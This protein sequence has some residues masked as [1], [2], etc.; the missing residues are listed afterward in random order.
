MNKIEYQES[1]EKLLAFLEKGFQNPINIINY[2][3][4]R[5]KCNE[6]KCKTKDCKALIKYFTDNNS[7]S[8]WS[9]KM[10]DKFD[11]LRRK[12]Y[13]PRLNYWEEPLNAFFTLPRI[14]QFLEE[15][16]K[17]SSE[18]IVEVFKMEYKGLGEKENFVPK[19][20]WKGKKEEWTAI[21]KEFK[22]GKR[23]CCD[24]YLK[25]YKKNNRSI[26][27]I[28]GEI[29]FAIPQRHNVWNEY[30][31]DIDKC[32]EWVKPD[33]T[34]YL[35]ERFN[36][37]RFDYALAILID[38]TGEETYSNLWNSEMKQMEATYLK[39]RIIVRLIQPK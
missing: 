6:L 1:I 15:E 26:P 24:Y 34:P 20:L 32:T 39:E 35:V 37:I 4:S 2:L 16:M 23:M 22:G 31:K 29:K 19:C 36:I 3:Q 10:L 7:E 28:V 33:T 30:K 12:W 8:P 25:N 18:E 14:A 21:P 38:L 5:D 27:N 17:F 13:K 11:E 9:R